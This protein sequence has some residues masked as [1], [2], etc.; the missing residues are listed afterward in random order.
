VP[1]NGGTLEL[2]DRENTAISADRQSRHTIRAT[3]AECSRR[4]QHIERYQHDDAGPAAGAPAAIA[5]IMKDQFIAWPSWTDVEAARRRGR[6]FAGDFDPTS[7]TAAPPLP[8]CAAPRFG[9]R[10]SRTPQPPASPGSRAHRA[11]EVDPAG[12]PAPSTAAEQEALGY[13]SMYIVAEHDASH[14]R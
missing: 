9:N 3:V 10:P 5:T 14:Q 11:I 6:S 1:G 4:F 13:H 8:S 12:M 2:D 7:G